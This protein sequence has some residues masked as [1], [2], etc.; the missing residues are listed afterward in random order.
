VLACVCLCVYEYVF[1]CVLLLFFTDC[2][3]H[4]FSCLAARLFNKLTRYSLYLLCTSPFYSKTLH[5]FCERRSPSLFC[6]LPFR[7]LQ[8]VG[9]QF[10][11]AFADLSSVCFS[12]MTSQSHPPCFHC[13]GLGTYGCS[14]TRNFLFHSFKRVSVI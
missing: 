13:F 7:L 10:M 2:R 1:V 9:I 14:T 12:I 5:I 11:T 6:G 8:S 4:L 3:I